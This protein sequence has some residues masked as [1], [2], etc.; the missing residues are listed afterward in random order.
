MPE[1]AVGLSRLRPRVDTEIMKHQLAQMRIRQQPPPPEPEKVVQPPRIDPI[2]KNMDMVIK[3]MY[4]YVPNVSSELV[5][6]TELDK[7]MKLYG[8]FMFFGL[9]CILTAV[10]YS[11]F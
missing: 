4:S 2:F 1:E 9:I 6:R 5:Y 8:F 11:L 3:D 10:A 7:D